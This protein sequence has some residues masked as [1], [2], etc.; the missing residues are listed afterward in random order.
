MADIGRQV[1][2]TQSESARH[3]LA[4][5][6]FEEMILD[7][8]SLLP[9]IQQ[10]VAQAY[11]PYGRPVDSARD[12]STYITAAGNMFQTYLTT[13]DRE[14][15]VMTQ[16][17]LEEYKKE[18]K[19]MSVETASR[20]FVKQCFERIY[21]E[22]NLFARVFK[23]EPAWNTSADSAFQT[24]KEINTT[25]VH[26][27]HLTPLTT[28]LQANLKTADLQTTCSV[29]GWLANE[30][31]IAEQDEDE[32]PFMRK[33]KEYAAQLLVWSLWPFT[34]AAFEA[35]ITK[36]I[37]KAT[38]Q[39]SSLVIEAVESG[40]A[41]S[42]AFVLVKQAINLLA[43][44]DRAMPKER[45]VCHSFTSRSQANNHRPRTAQSSSRLSVRPSK[46]CKR[47]RRGSS[48]SRTAPTPIYS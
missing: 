7:T 15:K 23:M 1:A 6:R 21:S 28:A 19:D 14:L 11:D 36:T 44:F 13:R 5:G 2:A 48:I 20:N 38:M 41:S 22:D 4:Y 33:T 12:N 16:H 34:D 43:M 9:N 26:P 31:S 37:T 39:D 8:Y 40:A 42:N 24:I 35:E 25:M 3:A 32:T 17:D 10:V 47:Q 30:Y 27:G 45:S 46:C 29:V 18:V